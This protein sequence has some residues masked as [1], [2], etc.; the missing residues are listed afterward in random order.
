MVLIVYNLSAHA[1]KLPEPPLMSTVSM[2]SILQNSITD[3]LRQEFRARYIETLREMVNDHLEQLAFFYVGKPETCN[4]LWIEEAGKISWTNV[5][6]LKKGLTA[7]GRDDLAKGWEEFETKRNLALLL[8]A[9]PKIRKDIPRQNRFEYVEA[10]SKPNPANYAL[11]KNS[12]RSLRKSKRSIIEEVMI[13]LKEQIETNLTEPWTERL[14][15]LI[16][17]AV[18]L[19]SKIGT[20]NDEF[21]SPLPE[22]VVRCSDVICSKIK[23]LGKWVRPINRWGFLKTILISVVIIGHKCESFRHLSNWPTLI[24]NQQP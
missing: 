1:Q 6:S 4:L 3:E 10:I 11:D 13:S 15:L 19:L 12:G 5:R 7:V 24:S 9:S 16:V 23:S 17:N 2:S 8:D 21:T 18:E 20:K 14:V 22:D